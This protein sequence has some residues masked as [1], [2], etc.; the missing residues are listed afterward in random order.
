[1]DQDKHPETEWTA[2]HARGL[3]LKN[4]FNKNLLTDEMI[5]REEMK[6]LLS[7]PFSQW[8]KSLQDKLGPHGAQMIE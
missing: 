1:M 2:R 6:I 7:K 4:L 5:D 3:L 8:P